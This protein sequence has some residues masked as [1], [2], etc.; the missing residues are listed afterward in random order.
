MAELKLLVDGLLYGGW[1]SVN[2]RRSIDHAADSFTLGITDR[3]PDAE[4]PRPIKMGTPC[5]IL[6]D[7][8]RLITGYVDDVHINYGSQNRDVNIYGRS[9]MA[10]LIDCARETKD[11]TQFNNQTFPEIATKLAKRFGL[12]VIDEIGLNNRRN[13]YIDVGE[14][15]F[16]FL[17]R[18]AN[19]DAVLFTSNPDGDIVI[20]RAGNKTLRTALELGRN[21]VSASGQFSMKDRYS[22]Y[23]VTGQH[24]GSDN[25]DAASAAHVMGQAEDPS[26]TRYRPTIVQPSGAL[27]IAEAKR[28][29]EYLRNVRYGRSMQV[30][31]TVLGWRH[32]DGLWA[33][34]HLVRIVDKWMGIDDAWLISEVRFRLD[35]NGER[36]EITVMPK[37]AFDI[38]PI[39]STAD[40]KWT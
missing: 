31:Y 11:G 10:D 7:D 2:V 16:E 36:T 5:E 12:G 25:I 4:D 6:I 3:W 37:E 14:S 40:E 38:V 8:E 33:P 22:H 29:S 30:S 26:V 34:N 18:Q 20:T 15:F 9:K 1:K 17:A 23:I 19:I 39:P 21:V 13:M 27:T 24:W 32:D 28:F 35:E